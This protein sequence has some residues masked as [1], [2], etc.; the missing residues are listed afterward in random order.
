MSAAQYAKNAEHK[1]QRKVA[2]LKAFRSKNF[3]PV[4]F[5]FASFGLMMR[6]ATPKVTRLMKPI[7]RVDHPKDVSVD[8]LRK[9]A[10]YT[11]PP[12]G[13]PETASPSARPSLFLK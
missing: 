12:T 7:A 13:A 9:T 10:E 5:R 3:L 6:I 11:T 4:D 1:V 8:R 2:S